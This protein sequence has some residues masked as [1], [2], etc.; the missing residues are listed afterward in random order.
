MIR[1]SRCLHL[2]NIVPAF[3]VITRSL[4]RGTDISR[5]DL[6]NL[7]VTCEDVLEDAALP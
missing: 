7:D 4:M 1:S 5:P 2:S 3:F 6:L